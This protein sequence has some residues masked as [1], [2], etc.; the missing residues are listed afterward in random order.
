MEL[1]EYDLTKS[2]RN[3]LSRERTIELQRSFTELLYMTLSKAC[4]YLELVA[5]QQPE[6]LANE[7]RKAL[8]AHQQ[9]LYIIDILTDGR[10]AIVQG[11]DNRPLQ[12]E[13]K[14]LFYA[15]TPATQSRLRDVGIYFDSF[16]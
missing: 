1:H 15:L 3:R 7:F 8:N 2:D 10:R 5:V 4:K 6:I 9:A 11:I 16:V 14:D 13:E 12:F